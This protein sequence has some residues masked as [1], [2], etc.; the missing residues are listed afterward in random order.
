MSY[1]NIIFLGNSGSGKSTACDYLRKKYGYK[2]LHPLRFYKS[3]IEDHYD[4]KQGGLDIPENKEVVPEGANSNLGGI[5]VDSYHFWKK[6][7]PYFTTRR[8]EKDLDYWW[9]LGTP[10]AFQAIRNVEEASA[11]KTKAAEL[12]QE[13]LIIKFEGRG[14]A[15]SSDIFLPDIK[16]ILSN[17]YPCLG[18][19]IFD[20][21]RNDKKALENYLD[22]FVSTY[23]GQD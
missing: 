17:S 14:K 11:I 4:L 19:S 16:F 22:K 6:H 7:D 10:I 15:K 21:S 8:L 1:P 9:D 23:Q 12:N 20:N 2:D 3:F 5:L 13:Y 18:F